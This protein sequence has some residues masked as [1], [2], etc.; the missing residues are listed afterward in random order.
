MAQINTL[1]SFAKRHQMV[2]R[3]ETKP[4]R[5]SQT[6]KQFYVCLRTTINNEIIINNNNYVTV[7]HFKN[8]Y[9][10]EYLD[11]CI[12]PMPSLNNSA[13]QQ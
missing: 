6:A 2:Y 8:V 4:Y 3:A 12:L 1:T 7:A 5:R 10:A 13:R 11:E 9:A